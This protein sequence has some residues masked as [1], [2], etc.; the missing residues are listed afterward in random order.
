MLGV[1]LGG[2]LV[3]AV[4]WRVIFLV[5]APLCLAAMV[6]AIVLL[7]ETDRGDAGR[8]DWAGAVLLGIGITSLLLATNRGS[9]WGWTSPAVIGLYCPG[10]GRPRRL[11][12]RRAP[13]R[14][15]AAAARAGSAGAT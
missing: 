12:R 2:P 5:Q 10:A 13:G 3:E 1:V 14:G 11:R 9:V 8:F 7:P 4:G 15:A 6:V